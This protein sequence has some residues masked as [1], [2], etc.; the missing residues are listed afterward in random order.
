MELCKGCILEGS[1]GGGCII[2]REFAEKQKNTEAKI[3]QMCD[4]YKIMTKEIL[5]LHYKKFLEK[6]GTKNERIKKQA[7]ETYFYQN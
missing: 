5:L 4:F 6:G 2:T 3:N 7:N 1:C